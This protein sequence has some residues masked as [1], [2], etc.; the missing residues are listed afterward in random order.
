M[1]QDQIMLL[2]DLK[3]SKD[4]GAASL[5][6]GQR[7]HLVTDMVKMKWIEQYGAFGGYRIRDEGIRALAN[8]GR[9]VK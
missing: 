3:A 5:G 2:L 1:T 4:R 9:K 8:T 7:L 6:C